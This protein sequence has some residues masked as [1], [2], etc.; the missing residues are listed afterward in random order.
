MVISP[1][2][3]LSIAKW[4]A[5][6]GLVGYI[7]HQVQLLG[8]LKESTKQLKRDYELEVLKNE[9]LNNAIEAIQQ[10]DRAKEQRIATARRENKKLAK[11]I[12][13]LR[14]SEDVGDCLLTPLPDDLV[15]GLHEA[16]SG[17]Y[18]SDRERE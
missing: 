17:L 2:Q 12:E 1:A 4:V 11:L 13:S 8:K 6:V 5:I 15:N 9:R 14:N 3:A 16:S 7:F 10:A 18:V